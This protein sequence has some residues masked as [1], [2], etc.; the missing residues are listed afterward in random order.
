MPKINKKRIV[1][2]E[3]NIK[4]FAERIISLRKEKEISQES[5]GKYLGFSRSTISCYENGLRAPDMKTLTVYSEFFDVPVDYLLGKTDIK[6][7]LYRVACFSD[8]SDKEFGKISKSGQE[9]IKSYIQFIMN[10][11][12]IKK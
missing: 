2:D 10:K 5:L 8:I 7:P 6:K 12:N 3:R 11:E 4:I 9:E 1:F